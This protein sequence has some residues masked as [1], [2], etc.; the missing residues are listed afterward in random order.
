MVYILW[1]LFGEFED[2]ST[3]NKLNLSVR[4]VKVD[5]LFI[6][7]SCEKISLEIYCLCV[8][9]YDVQFL[10]TISNKI[11]LK[12]MRFTVIFIWK[13]NIKISPPNIHSGTVFYYDEY[14][15]IINI[16]WCIHWKTRLFKFAKTHKVSKKKI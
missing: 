14:L 10:F 1:C 4:L 8:K 3:D 11:L 9:F 5:N 7:T 13:W 6:P 16:K 15:Q 2:I 12:K